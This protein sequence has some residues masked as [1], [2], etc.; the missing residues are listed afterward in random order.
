[1]AKKTDFDSHLDAIVRDHVSELVSAITAAVRANVADEIQSL[2]ATGGGGT[3]ARRLLKPKKR[4]IL[5]CIAPG[6]SNP[7]KGP[8]FHY[9]CDKHKDASKKDYES[10]RKAKKSA[11][12]ASA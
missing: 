6:C 11:G 2:L 7:S 10:W 9:L 12:G 5:P 8:R 3:A 1:M 4:R